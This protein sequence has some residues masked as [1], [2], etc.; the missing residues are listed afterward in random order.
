MS[1]AAGRTTHQAGSAHRPLRADTPAAVKLRPGNPPLLGLGMRHRL[2]TAVFALLHDAPLVD[3]S[4][5]TRLTAVFL[6]DKASAATDH[7]A[8]QAGEL[9]R[10]LGVSESQID[11][12][13][14]PSLRSSHTFMS[15]STADVRGKAN[16][17]YGNTPV[18][19]ALRVGRTYPL[20]RTRRGLASSK[21]EQ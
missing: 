5:A 18:W 20:A 6:A 7:A 19:R 3:Q 2:R 21:E 11:Y 8:G 1:I 12:S 9:G 10:R 15:R 16:G 13:V 17:L 4:D 14:P